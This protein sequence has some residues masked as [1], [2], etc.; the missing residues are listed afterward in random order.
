MT[1]TP[2]TQAELLAAYNRTELACMGI[3]F[4]AAMQDS[5]LRGCLQAMANSDRRWAATTIGHGS[6]RLDMITRGHQ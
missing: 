2:P 4:D 5:A 3:S 1:R 6:R